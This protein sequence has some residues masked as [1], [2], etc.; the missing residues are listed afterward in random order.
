MPSSKKAG[1]SKKQKVVFW[2]GVAGFIAAILRI[3]APF[4]IKRAIN[5]TLSESP[6]YVGW[7]TDVDLSLLGGTA[8][9]HNIELRIKKRNLPTRK[10][11]DR[12]PDA[13]DPMIRIK[14]V[15]VGLKW[16]GFLGKKSVQEVIVESPRVSLTWKQ[17]SNNKS[18]DGK[19]IEKALAELPST[20]NEI[21]I[22]N[23]AFVLH[24]QKANPET[25]L[26]FERL[27]GK[28]I[29]SKADS[30]GSL[31]LRGLAQGH[32]KLTIKARFDPNLAE[33][34]AFEA[35]ASI[36]GVKLRKLRRL[37][38]YLIGITAEKGE[39]D[40]ELNL[41]AKNGKIRGLTTPTIRGVDVSTDEDK[42]S[43]GR[44]LKEKAADVKMLTLEN[45]EIISKKVA[46]EVTLST[47]DD[48][49]PAI[50][51]FVK[52]AFEVTFEM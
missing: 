1:Y 3:S 10:D 40:L 5:N 35:T 47:V 8:E 26:L 42:S 28:I 39:L 52:K 41:S 11:Y 30:S 34:P 2:L 46:Q 7:V 48:I 49:F 6:K 38:N 44:S 18:S 14:T 25:M 17:L 31:N 33:P 20:L 45:G 23:G 21:K 43:V 12:K 9:L 22:K 32:G 4:F 13:S 16:W 29:V 27:N 15:R 37:T 36:T 24:I 19:G 51:S 50:G